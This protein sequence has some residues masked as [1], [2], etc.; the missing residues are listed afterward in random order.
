MKKV[1]IA[2]VAVVCLAASATHVRADGYKA[3]EPDPKHEAVLVRGTMNLVT[4]WIELPRNLVYEGIKL[5]LIGAVWGSLK[6]SG[7]TAGRTIAGLVDLL[8]FGCAG[9]GM[10]NEVLPYFVWEKTWAPEPRPKVEDEKKQMDLIDYI[11]KEKP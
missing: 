5:P 10:Y 11:K 2:V 9:R 3:G 8:S 4:G 6:G 1:R 7:L